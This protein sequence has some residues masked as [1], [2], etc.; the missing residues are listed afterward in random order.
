MEK[1]SE[2]SWIIRQTPEE[3]AEGNVDTLF[4]LIGDEKHLEID[5]DDEYEGVVL[6]IREQIMLRDLLLELHPL[7]APHEV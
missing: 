2:T 3:I 1:L 6:T 5:A 7:E 4:S